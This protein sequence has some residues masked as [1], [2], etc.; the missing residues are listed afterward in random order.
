MK[1][2]I[3]TVVLLT[4][5]Q[6][7]SFA[8][9]T[10]LRHKLAALTQAHTGIVGVSLKCLEDNDTLTLNNGHRYPMQS[11]YKFPLALFVLHKVDKGELKLD[12]KIHITKQDLHDTWSPLRDKYPNGNIDITIGEL[13]DYT[14]SK[15]D[16]NTCDILFKLVGGTEPANQ[17]IHSL[18][19]DD[20]SIVATE[21]EMTKKWNIQYTNWTIPTAMTD[22]L[23]GL[24]HG[25]YLS[26]T[27][28]AFLMKLMTESANSDKRIKGLLP[29]GTVVAHK[30]GTSG[31]KKGMTAAINDLGIISMPNGK[32]LAIAIYVSNTIDESNE[33]E[34][35]IA[36]IAR[37]VYDEY[38]SK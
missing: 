35:V 30:T 22:L 6:F 15:S 5:L 16:N 27:S 10:A 3:T 24:Y 29:A 11:T 13:L 19:I 18:G 1:K 20:I 2:F 8:Q 12:Q 32:H 23:N 37:A 36:E 14:V 17:Y 26:A 7:T 33:A 34:H 38:L 25:K 28:T 21:H 31:N 4:T 9:H